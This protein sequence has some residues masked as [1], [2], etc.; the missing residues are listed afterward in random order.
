M[1]H[2]STL[3]QGVVS[4]A[5][6]LIIKVHS[7]DATRDSGALLHAVSGCCKDWE[8][9]KH[10]GSYSQ[11]VVEGGFESIILHEAMLHRLDWP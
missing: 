1:E 10:T 3:C 7:N 2:C 5:V 8:S 11:D 9:R 4:V 6:K